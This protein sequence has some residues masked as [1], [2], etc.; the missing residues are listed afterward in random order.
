MSRRNLASITLTL[1]AV[2]VVLIV[3]AWALERVLLTGPGSRAVLAMPS[4]AREPAP[5]GSI[6]LA[7]GKPFARELTTGQLHSYRI[8]LTPGQFMR[9]TAVN[10]GIDIGLALYEPGGQ[11]LSQSDSRR[12]DAMT[13]SALA[14]SPGDY[15]LEVR[16]LD[17]GDARGGYE[18]RTC[19]VRM[20]A[21][22]DGH[23]IA[24][25]RSRA[26][27]DR[28]SGE[29]NAESSRLAISKY[30][31][32]LSYWKLA[33]DLREEADAFLSIGGIQQVLGELQQSLA[34]YNHALRLYR[35]ARD[36]RGEGEALNEIGFVYSILCEND[37]AL[38]F[39]LRALNLNQ[40]TGNR[41][42]TA[43]ALNNLGDAYYNFGKLKISLEH[44]HKAL[45]MWRELND[46]GGEA[47]ALLNQGYVYSDSGEMQKAF[48]CYNQALS[49]WQSRDERRWQGI[50]F[51][52]LG[53][54]YSRLGET[55]HALDLF[56]R[57]KEIIE[58]VGDQIEEGRILSGLAFIY[59]H[60]DEKQQALD[61][62]NQAL[63][64]YERV[65]Y[66]G[67]QAN[68][69]NS[70][71]NVYYST[72]DYEKALE[73]FEQNLSLSLAMNDKREQSN[74]LKGIGMVYEARGNRGKALSYYA[75][76]LPFYQSERDL[77]AEAD[78]LRIIGQIHEGSG[79]KQRAFYYYNKALSRSRA[80][81]YRFG[82]AST[83][84]N[85][86][87]VER[88]L[89]KLAEARARMETALETVE[90]LR[91]KVVDQDLRN[92]YFASVRR[93]Y[94]LY[95]DLLMQLHG[96]RPDAA[97]DVA[98]Y[99]ASE[100]ARARSMLE[101]LTA[102]RIGVN[103]K[104]D[105]A[106]LERERSLRQELNDKASQRM[107]LSDAGRATEEAAAIGRE[108]DDLARQHHELEARIRV[109]SLNYAALIQ[110]RPLNLK[111]IQEQ[112]IDD[113]TL[114][115]QYS[116]GEA[117]SYL[118]AVTKT[119]ISSYEL[120]GRDRV[121]SL[122]N[123]VRNIL[124]APQIVGGE[125]FEQ[126]KAR[127]IESEMKYRRDASSLSNMLLGPVA[128]RLE[129]RRLIII[130][131]GALQY[132]S[133]SALPDPE[134]DNNNPVPLIVRHEITAQPSA[135]TLA[136]L[137]NDSWKRLPASNLLIVF[138][139]PVFEKDDS[140]LG[141]GG[142]AVAV[143]ARQGGDREVYRALRGV[144]SLQEGQHIPRLFASRDEAEAVMAAA[145]SGLKA[146]GFE[147]NKTRA[148]SPEL[149]RYRIIH[150]ATHGILDS[151]N[152]DLSGLVLSL[153]DKDGQPQDGYLRLN[154]IYN[155]ELPSDLVVLSAC[156]TGLGKQIKGEGMIGLTRGFMYAGAS[157][158]MA[159]LWKV[160]DE[161]TAQLI[162]Y[163]YQ[164]MLAKK[165]SPAEAL[166]RAQ[167]AMWSQDRW[168]S[169]YF[170]AA[171]V[172]QG[173]YGGV[174]DAGDDDGGG[175]SKILM[176]AITVIILLF[177]GLF[178]ARQIMFKKHEISGNLRS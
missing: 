126:R 49:I 148:T 74:A 71:G 91:T 36:R 108:I 55:Q 141:S 110:T 56:K 22:N 121:E 143:A 58:V 172:L 90:S 16:P 26:E 112:A 164:E 51:T 38:S 99:E 178:A 84:Y 29:S 30:E 67:A 23:R 2:G 104:V 14:D 24:A 154:D 37:K 137:R 12:R 125:S 169:P 100:K 42:A 17:G 152:P 57:A 77:R 177:V 32:A 72:Q 78:T 138:A 92:S 101:T 33:G 149:K 89:G 173:E 142:G 119:E 175:R 176:P 75:R 48:D 88:D 166:R 165:K 46:R 123:Q 1:S 18:I 106:L 162:K 11:L 59:Y 94:E 81:E 43:R 116:L 86:A 96:R 174:I 171:F 127:L 54:L 25:E 93:H 160:D 135:S 52:A 95:I 105:P 3:T 87:R 111:T 31:E 163:F 124:T 6:I 15:R 140:R 21:P 80:A 122:A 156:N 103:Q 97:F 65:G 158:V 153:F 45:S 10:T 145:P 120:P 85:M 19:E 170:W 69:I 150:F 47:L 161:A 130:A 63:R 83:L 60:L 118:W 114:L 157:R 39:C 28:L 79:Q 68:M 147:A 40:A 61:Y 70:I 34:S 73:Y 151:E 35:K 20:A 132:T 109:A 64:L 131:D 155:L 76:A 66:R 7:P 168:R 144:G 13:L 128:G 146:V 8:A 44:Y 107:R 82:E 41:G 113:D 9:V 139:D 167:I 115:L 4:A 133:F 62:Y 50:T 102:A 53:R 98:A 129:N 159:S 134:S 5:D 117:R 27:A 136:A